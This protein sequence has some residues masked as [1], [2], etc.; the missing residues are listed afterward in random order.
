MGEVLD[1]EIGYIR[2]MRLVGMDVE[3]WLRGWWKLHTQLLLKRVELS[4]LN[5]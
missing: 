3:A 2:M 5:L 4:T 1:E